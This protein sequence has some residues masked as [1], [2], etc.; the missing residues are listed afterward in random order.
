M[1]LDISKLDHVRV[2]GEKLTARCPA[3]AEAGHDQTRNHLI[4]G[5]GGFG[6]VVYPGN[7]PDARDHRK[8]IFALCGIRE[9]KRLV[10]RRG[11]LGRLGRVNQSHSASEPLKTGLLGRLGRL[12]LTHLTAELTRAGSKDRTAEKLNEFKRGVL[13]TPT[14]RPHRPLSER[15]RALLVRAGADDDPIIFEA[16][17]LFDARIV[18][19]SAHDHRTTKPTSARCAQSPGGERS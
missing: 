5:A 18:E 14:V 7:S 17:R 2:R 19:W 9:I 1:S 4:I 12:F 13:N 3:C 8:R 16:L 6:C 11:D 15:E 10:V